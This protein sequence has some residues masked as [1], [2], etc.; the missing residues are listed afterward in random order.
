MSCQ[1]SKGKR[2]NSIYRYLK[3]EL[4]ERTTR[5][6]HK[7]FKNQNNKYDGDKIEWGGG[8]FKGIISTFTR[9][10]PPALLWYT[11]TK[12]PLSLPPVTCAHT[13]T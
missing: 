2:L 8:V 4:H 6:V 1:D 13:H 3:I 12:T 9:C 10:L 7:L 11:Y 5:K